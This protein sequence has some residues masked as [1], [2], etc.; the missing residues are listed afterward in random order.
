MKK[1][2]FTFQCRLTAPASFSAYKGSMLRGSLGAS[3]KKTCCTMHRASCEDCMLSRQC[4]FSILFTGRA[5]TG[6]AQATTLPPPYCLEPA[7]T[8]KT[9]Y[10][11][12]EAF[13]FKLT[14]FSYAVEYLPYFVHAVILAGQHGMGKRTEDTRGTF[15]L[16]QLL[17]DGQPIFQKELQKLAVP[18]GENL[19]L[20]VWDPVPAPDGTLVVRL[21]TPCRFKEDNRLSAGLS[22]RQLFNL[23]I[24]RIR[25]VWAL[26]GESVKFDNFS[27]MLD[28]A[29]AVSTLESQLYWKDWTRYSTRQKA[30]MQLGGLQGI[31]RYHGDLAAFL[32]FFTLA[33]QLHIGKQTSFGLGQLSIQWI[34]DE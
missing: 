1:A 18:S 26:D 22:F 15:E 34:P 24:R 20:P 11:T 4:T 25:T 6:A 33:E 29:D 8:G 32:P 9:L 27:A 12:G 13:T 30:A 2:T 10:D 23:V 21:E 3:L 5:A 28:R 7:D 17:H 14:L 16:E 19:S 31:V